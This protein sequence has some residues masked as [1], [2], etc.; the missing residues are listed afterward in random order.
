MLI[1]MLLLCYA[2]RYVYYVDLE[3]EESTSAEATDRSKDKTVE[4]ASST[5]NNEASRQPSSTLTAL[6]FASKFGV[7]PNIQLTAV[8]EN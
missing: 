8:R 3:R 7:V 1:E 2:A 6:D 5:N 4:Q